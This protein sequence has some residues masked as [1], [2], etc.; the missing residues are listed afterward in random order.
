MGAMDAH[1]S[2]SHRPGPT[3][4]AAR[5]DAPPARGGAVPTDLPTHGC[6]RCGRRVPVSV[7][8]CEACNPLGLSQPAASQAHGTVFLAI[9]LAVIGL[10]LL[11]RLALAGV[12]PFEGSVVAVEPAPGGLAVTLSVTNEGSRAGATTCRI[13]DPSIPGIGPESAQVLSP[14]I[15]PGAT[16]TFTKTIGELGSV[17]RPLAAAC[18][19]R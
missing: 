17:P 4:L 19:S 6:V 8:L 18:R 14:R 11:G 2:L 12:G 15:E 3:P 13:Y 16:V 9:G 1:P 10:A 5:N 7:A